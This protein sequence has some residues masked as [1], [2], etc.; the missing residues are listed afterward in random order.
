M[1]NWPA[2]LKYH[3]EYELVFIE[4][5]E[6]W[7]KDPDLYYY[8]YDSA[9]RLLDSDGILYRLDQIENNYVTPTSMNSTMRVPEF[10]SML[11]AHM[12]ELGHCCI[13]KIS[14]ESIPEGIKIVGDSVK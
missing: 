13:A 7:D 11:K 6:Q 5:Q 10:E 2:V 4:N 9:D 14:I 8:A 3:G 12:S 1:I